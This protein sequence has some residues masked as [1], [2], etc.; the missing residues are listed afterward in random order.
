MSRALRD[1]PGVWSVTTEKGCQKGGE[2]IKGWK[3]LTVEEICERVSV[4]I[5]VKPSRYYVDDEAGIK[6]FRSANISES[7][8]VDKDWVYLSPE[9]HAMNEKSALKAGDVLVVRSGAPGTACVVTPEYEGTNCIDV[10]FARPD[11]RYVLPEYLAAFTNSSVGKKH[12]LGNQGGLALKH[13]NVSAYKRMEV[14]LPP[15]PE[16]RKIAAILRTWDEAIEA[17]TK[18]VTALNARREALRTKLVTKAD[19]GGRPAVFGEFLTESRIL[20]SD[21]ASAQKITVKL[22]GKGAVPKSDK[23]DGSTKTRY[24]RRSPGQL[25]YSKLDFLNGAFALVPESLQGYESSL[26]LPAFDIS[27]HVNPKWLIEYLT[28]PAYYTA[29]LHLARGQRKARRIAPADFLASPVKLPQRDR[30]NEI[31]AVLTVADREIAFRETELDTLTRQKRGLMQ[32]LLTGE[33][34]V[35]TTDFCHAEPRGRK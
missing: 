23:R 7:K 32:K 18:L 10:V 28:R 6:A 20:G 29:Q 9:G 12:V 24:Y 14:V 30:Q 8:I 16:Q 1:R 27:E 31:A 19:S 11:T 34:W 3:R 22:Y 21:G 5:V 26:D 17:A 2:M 35:N 33:W 4:G 15:L 25:I 13:F